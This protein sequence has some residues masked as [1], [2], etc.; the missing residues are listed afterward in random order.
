MEL[1][2]ERIQWRDCAAYTPVSYNSTTV[3]TEEF[4]KL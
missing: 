2:L 1:D 3:L 4:L